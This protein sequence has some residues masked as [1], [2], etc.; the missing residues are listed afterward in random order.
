MSDHD[1]LDKVIMMR[2]MR[3]ERWIL[4]NS[5]GGWQHPIH[6]H[7][8]EFRIIRRNGRQ[9]QCGNPDFSRKD[10]VRLGFNDEV[11]V[12]MRFRDFRGGEKIQLPNTGP[13]EHAAVVLWEG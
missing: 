13:Q 6:I 8:E 4:R 11:E 10:V 3:T 9:V 7:L 12:V 2:G 5:S 1:G